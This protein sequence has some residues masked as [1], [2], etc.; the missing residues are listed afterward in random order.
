MLKSNK[1]I[2]LSFASNDLKKSIFR[3]K[4]QAQE[5]K[6]YDRIRI[7]TYA[8]LDTNFKLTLKKLL[9]DGKK[10]GFGY[11]MWKPYLVKKILEEINYGDVI[12]YMD[13][14]FH[15]LKENKKKFEDYLKFISEE[16]NW[17]LTFQYHNL[18]EEKLENISFPCREERKYSKGDLL[19]FFGFYNNSSVTE[20][21]QYMAGCFFIKKSK[22]SISF[23]NEWLDIFYKRFDLVDDTDSKLKNLNGFLENRHDQSV[24]SLLCKKYNLQSFSAYECDWAYL[25]N[26]R[27]WVHN[28]KSPF[29]AKRDLRYGILKRFYNRQKKTFLRKKRNFVNLWQKILKVKT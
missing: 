15:L 22:K 12:N 6:F 24:F 10:R 4:K 23:I 3:F 21:P 25:N 2:L 1:I 19:D 28:K 27:T 7:I 17:I 11:F 16:N 18:M 29:L 26:E 8:D 9:L 14:G 20:T 13:I 5:T